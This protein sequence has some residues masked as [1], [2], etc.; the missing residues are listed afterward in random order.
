[1][2]FSKQ[3]LEPLYLTKEKTEP[4][5]HTSLD[6]SCIN[7]ERK[8]PGR[9]EHE[10]RPLLDHAFRNAVCGVCGAVISFPVWCGNRLCPICARRRQRKYQKYLLKK[11]KTPKGVKNLRFIT[12]TGKTCDTLEEAV[13]DVKKA[14]KRLKDRHIWK[15]NIKGGAYSLE[16]CKTW[17]GWD[18]RTK[19]F[20]FAKWYVHVHIVAEGKYIDQTEL[21]EA[22]REVTGGKSYVVDIRKVY[23]YYSF[24]K[25]LS[26][27]PFK[28]MDAELWTE[29]IKGEFNTFMSNR[30]LFVK[31][32]SWHNDHVSVSDLPSVCP[33]CLSVGSFVFISAYEQKLID[34]PVEIFEEWGFTTS[35]IGSLG[36][37]PEPPYPTLNCWGTSILSVESIS[38]TIFFVIDFIPLFLNPHEKARSLIFIA[39]FKSHEATCIIG[40]CEIRKIT[41]ESLNSRDSINS[42]Y[43]IFLC[44]FPRNT[45]LFLSP[46]SGIQIRTILPAQLEVV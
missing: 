46:R 20:I 14:V 27:Y 34:E 15:Y 29:S 43:S 31:F 36:S 32:G 4:I 44:H 17:E 41:P 24:V 30:R 13:N 37:R 45:D 2:V 18:I 26:K 39:L 10:D 35:P 22:W 1:M 19:T 40:D 23:S 42:S 28:P 16:V 12:F 3:I 9:A 6:P 8:E 7:S 38:T 5:G 25:E 33:Y 21:K 11:V